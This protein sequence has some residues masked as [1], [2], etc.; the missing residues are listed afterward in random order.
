M[1]IPTAM[2]RGLPYDALASERGFTLVELLV[3]LV[4]GL[5]TFSALLAILDVT[6]SGTSRV[7]SRVN[8]TQESR[9]ALAHIENELHSS[10]V[11]D[12]T[13]PIQPGSDDNTLSFVNGYGSAPTVTPVQHTIAYDATNKTLTETTGANTTTLLGNVD[14][15]GTTPVFQYFAFEVPR[16]SPGR[17]G[18]PYLDPSG[19]QYQMLLDGDSTLPSGATLNGNPVAPNTI[20]ANSPLPLGPLPLS[21]SDIYS[22]NDAA[23]AAGVLINLRVYPSGGNDVN[24]NTSGASATVTDMIV[25]RLTPVANHDGGSPDLSPCV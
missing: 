11:G 23:M 4:A 20:P 2:T 13:A 8:A 15:A 9:T 18:T 14:Q 24:P 19:N 21:D 22:T 5:A 7:T 17:T 3:T 12:L 25:M 1:P 16:D 6:M 10:C